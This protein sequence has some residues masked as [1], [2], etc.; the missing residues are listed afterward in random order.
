MPLPSAVI[1]RADFVD[2]QHL[3]E[4]RAFDVEDLARERQDGL[5]LAVA[6]LFGR[7]AGGVTLDDEQFRKRR[8]LFLSSRRACPAVRRCRARPCGASGR[9]PCARPRE[10]ARASTILLGDC[11]A[12]RAGS[13]RRN[14]SSFALTD[15]LDDAP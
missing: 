3:V 14:S 15:L 9:G 7:T 1:M 6:A 8:L 5:G 10:H 2:G 13:P 4:P 11:V 12:P